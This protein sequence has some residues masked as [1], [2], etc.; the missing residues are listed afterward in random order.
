[1]PPMP[2]KRKSDAELSKADEVWNSGIVSLWEI[3]RNNPIG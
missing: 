3:K 1:M 2:E